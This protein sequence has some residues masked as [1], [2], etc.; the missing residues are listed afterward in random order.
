MGRR[1]AGE[2]REE[3]TLSLESSYDCASKHTKGWPSHSTYDSLRPQTRGV[4]GLVHLLRFVKTTVGVSGSP[5]VRFAPSL[6]AA[7]T[8]VPGVLTPLALNSFP[9]ETFMTVINCFVLGWL[10]VFPAS[11]CPLPSPPLLQLP[12]FPQLPLTVVITRLPQL[13]SV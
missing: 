13:I 8:W 2:E 10:L 9:V 11:A 3:R 5:L 12:P 6:S 7:S 4:V 1:G